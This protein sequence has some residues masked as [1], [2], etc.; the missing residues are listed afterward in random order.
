MGLNHKF[1]AFKNGKLLVIIVDKFNETDILQD[2]TKKVKSLFTD[3]NLGEGKSITLSLTNSTYEDISSV[4]IQDRDNSLVY[5]L[6][7][8]IVKCLT[9]KREKFKS[10]LRKSFQKSPKK[11]ESVPAFNNSL[12]YGDLYYC[13]HIYHNMDDLENISS[14]TAI[15]GFKAGDKLVL[16]ENKTIENFKKL[17]NKDKVKFYEI[18]N[19]KKYE[20]EKQDDIKNYL[21]GYG[22]VLTSIEESICKHLGLSKNSKYEHYIKIE[23]VDRCN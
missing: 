18:K 11:E 22:L 12:L 10:F 7:E 6:D 5:R 17:E 9:S 14:D 16:L 13:S 3:K 23:K 15:E 1:E 4:D 19:Y 20:V 2:K 8:K 21:K